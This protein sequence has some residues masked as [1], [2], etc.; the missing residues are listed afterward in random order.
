M[1]DVPNVAGYPIQF[2]DRVKNGRAKGLRVGFVF[3][4]F[5]RNGPEARKKI[6]IGMVLQIITA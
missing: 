1:S 2:N 4:Q 3:Q 5:V 6:S